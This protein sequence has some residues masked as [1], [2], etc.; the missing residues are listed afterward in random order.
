MVLDSQQEDAR[1]KDVKAARNTLMDAR[2]MNVIKADFILK[3]LRD[4]ASG[5]E[6]QSAE[7]IST[8][9]DQTAA[10]TQIVPILVM[11]V[12]P[13]INRITRSHLTTITRTDLINGNFNFKWILVL[14]S[15]DEFTL[16]TKYF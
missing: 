4:S 9:P 1:S 2:N 16:K 13:T 10:F 11:E 15:L 14:I 8:D 3:L 7:P 6:F 5:K 12:I